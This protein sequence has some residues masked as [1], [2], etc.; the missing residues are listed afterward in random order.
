MKAGRNPKTGCV[1][2]RELSKE[3]TEELARSANELCPCSVPDD[4]FLPAQGDEDIED[5]ID[6]QNDDNYW[7]D[8]DIDS[9]E[10]SQVPTEESKP[11]TFFC[12]NQKKR[13]ASHSRL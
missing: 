11:E 3:D 9:L 8:G 7:S 5:E 2:L 12:E 4:V 10:T 13:S 1:L 6:D